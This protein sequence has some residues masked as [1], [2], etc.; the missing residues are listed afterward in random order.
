MVVSKNASLSVLFKN[1]Q[2]KPN[3]LPTCLQEQF[4]ID[5]APELDPAC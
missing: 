1:K 2:T 4:G 3:L 5:P